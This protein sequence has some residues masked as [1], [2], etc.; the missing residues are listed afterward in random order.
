MGGDDIAS[1]R[2]INENDDVLNKNENEDD[3]ENVNDSESKTD[4]GCSVIVESTGK[5]LSN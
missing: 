4:C 2:M 5:K 3:D 1:G